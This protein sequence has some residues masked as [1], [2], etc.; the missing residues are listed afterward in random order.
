MILPGI[1][2]YLEFPWFDCLFPETALFNR[3]SHAARHTK[4]RGIAIIIAK[5]NAVADTK[6]LDEVI[7]VICEVHPDLDA[8]SL[9][10]DTD[11]D[12]LGTKFAGTD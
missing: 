12:T 2:L 6:I 8:A 11:F 1:R 3:K 5:E 10:S 9:S 4:T 7:E